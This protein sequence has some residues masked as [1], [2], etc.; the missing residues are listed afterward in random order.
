[1]K[2]LGKRE[3]D[4]LVPGL[5]QGEGRPAQQHHYHHSSDLHNAKSLFARLVDAFDVFVPEI[6]GDGE[7]Q[8]DRSPVDVNMRRTIEN[9]V[10][11]AR[12]PS[13]NVGRHQCV[14][15]QTR[16]ILARRHT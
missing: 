2:I 1:M 7:G 13:V 14:I 8:D 10:N 4:G 15:D 6:H 3:R 16:D 12:N 11:G 5:D 9:G